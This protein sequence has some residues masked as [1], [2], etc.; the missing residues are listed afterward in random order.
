MLG[1][2]TY[3]QRGTS[4]QGTL[5]ELVNA[6]LFDKVGKHSPHNSDRGGEG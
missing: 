5:E 2:V 1:S 4:G 3:G 6:K